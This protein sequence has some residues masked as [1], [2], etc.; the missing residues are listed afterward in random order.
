MC[1]TS[2]FAP[3]DRRA[4]A[5]GGKDSFRCGFPTE[6]PFSNASAR[7]AGVIRLCLRVLVFCKRNV[8][9]W[10]ISALW[11]VRICWNIFL[12]TSCRPRRAVVP[13]PKT[14]S[15]PKML[16]ETLKGTLAH[17]SLPLSLIGVA[18]AHSIIL[19]W[20]DAALH[21]L[22]QKLTQ[23]LPIWGGPVLRTIG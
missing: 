9:M 18:S 23:P 21:V 7:A 2:F 11:A 10:P 6:T 17:C 14:T 8:S 4:H 15:H 3:L 19:S 22:R 20:T 13:S 12:F 1:R 16:C 5:P